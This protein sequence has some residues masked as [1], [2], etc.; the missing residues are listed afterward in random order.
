MRRAQ[1]IGLIAIAAVLFLV[2]SALLARALSVSGAE[3]AAVTRLIDDEARGDTAAVVSLIGGCRASAP[4]RTRAAALT[5]ALRR[6]GTVTIAQLTTSTNFSLGPTIGTA[7]VAWIA[8]RSL[9]R[10]QCIRVRHNGDV[11][12]GFTVTLVRVSMRIPSGDDCPSRF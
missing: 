5:A 6:P 2:I 12:S 10:V 9:P 8:G 1:L 3:Q 4:C 11:L 7:R